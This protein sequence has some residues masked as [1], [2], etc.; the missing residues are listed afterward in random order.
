VPR[1]Q[2]CLGYPRAHI[3]ET[4]ETYFHKALPPNDLCGPDLAS[5]T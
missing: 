3:A 5:A 2:Q 4:D 1:T